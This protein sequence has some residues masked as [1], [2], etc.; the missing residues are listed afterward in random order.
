MFFYPFIGIIRGNGG[1]LIST[2]QTIWEGLNWSF[3]TNILLTIIPAL[4]CITLHEL[5]HGYIA[6]KLGDNT[7][8]AAGRLTL[9]PLKHIDIMGLAMMVIFKFGWA[10]PV[11]INMRNFKDPK[12]GMAISAAAGPISNLLIAVVVLFLYGL[13]YIPLGRIGNIG[14]YISQMLYLTAYLSV[15]LAIFNIIPIP[16]LDGSKVLY[17]FL[18]DAAYWKLMRYERYGM[19]F[20]IAFI[21]MLNNMNVNPLGA[22]VTFVFDKLIFVAQFGFDIVSNII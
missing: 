16:P 18:S 20:L 10:K 9:N 6:Y 14:D 7:A 2:F 15:A 17:A 21:F 8:K 1:G 19:I 5:A 3:L 22:A 4:L 12:R 13:L 11:P